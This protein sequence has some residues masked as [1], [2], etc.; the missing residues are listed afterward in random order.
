[1][2]S[3]YQQRLMGNKNGLYAKE[4]EDLQKEIKAEDQKFHQLEQQLGSIQKHV[5]FLQGKIATYED[6][7]K[8]TF[9]IA[10]QI[11]DA[12]IKQMEKLNKELKEIPPLLQE[13]LQE[14]PKNTS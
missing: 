7:Q 8:K 12:K 11:A 9:Q 13:V 2:K 3:K 4:I 6:L 5:I 1:M 14:D 10:D